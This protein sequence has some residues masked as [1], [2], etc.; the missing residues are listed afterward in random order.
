MI[1][2]FAIALDVVPV[3]GFEPRLHDPKAPVLPLDVAVV[4][5][6]AQYGRLVG[7]LQVAFD[8]CRS[9]FNSQPKTRP[10]ETINGY[11]AQKLNV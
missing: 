10:I 7:T 9:I 6:G 4:P 1:G 2:R 11:F 5:T 8:A 3:R